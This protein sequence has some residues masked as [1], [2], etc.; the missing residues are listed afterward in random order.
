M[1]RMVRLLLPAGQPRKQVQLLLGQKLHQ[2]PFSMAADVVYGL[3]VPGLVP[4]HHPFIP[5]PTFSIPLPI[6]RR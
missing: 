6:L 3:V 2:L 4:S 5:P 1:W